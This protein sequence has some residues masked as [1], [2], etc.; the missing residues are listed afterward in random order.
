M[1]P[2][3]TSPIPPMDSGSPA[4]S[5]PA[6]RVDQNGIALLKFFPKPN[7]LDRNITKGNYNYITQWEGT[8]P[9]QLYTLKIDYLA[10]SKDNIS[11]SY[12]AQ[13]IR[14]ESFNGSGLT[15]SEERRVGK[16]RQ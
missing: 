16:E 4:T 8:N 12:S 6:S 2:R 14:G 3:S 5:F 15:R 11:G 7:S 13:R 9:T 10:T 1:A